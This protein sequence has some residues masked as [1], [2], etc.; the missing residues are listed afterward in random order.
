[1]KND[2]SINEVT[3][4]GRHSE[5]RLLIIAKLRRRVTLLRLRLHWSQ[6]QKWT[7]LIQF[8]DIWQAIARK[9][10]SGY[11]FNQITQKKCT[12]FPLKI[13]AMSW[14]NIFCVTC[15]QS[16]KKRLLLYL[17]RILFHL[18]SLQ[19][20]WFRTIQISWVIS[21]PEWNKMKIKNIK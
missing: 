20:I 10:V 21:L 13:V 19:I 9:N 6:S 17:N 3:D 7:Q 8:R 18:A 11:A 1:M 2:K 16:Q 12:R 5:G 15:K 4:L 14:R